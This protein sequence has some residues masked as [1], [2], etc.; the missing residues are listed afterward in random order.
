MGELELPTWD[1]SIARISKFIKRSSLTAAPQFEGLLDGAMTRLA[2]RTTQMSPFFALRDAEVATLQ[3]DERARSM[4]VE[5][6]RHCITLLWQ[7]IA[8]K[9]STHSHLLEPVTCEAGLEI[10]GDRLN[11]LGTFP[12]TSI[13][14]SIPFAPTSC[15]LNPLAERSHPP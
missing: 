4:Y 9:Y 11:P 13:W 3:E 6:H 15:V 2:D 10:L 7:S 5:T 12:P 1:G 14:Y 8:Q